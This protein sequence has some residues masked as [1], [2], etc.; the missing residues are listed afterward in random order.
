[1]EEYAKANA[2]PI[3]QPE[4]M[5]FIEVLIKS[6][7]A[8]K[9][10][11][12]GSAIGYSAISMAMCGASVT[13][14]ERDE[15]MLSVVRSNIKK[16]AFDKRIK[17]LAGDALSVVENLSGTFDFIF[18]DAAKGQYPE[19]L[20][21]LLRLLK[22]GGILVSDNILYRGMVATDELAIRRKTTIIKRLRAY[23]DTLCHSDELTTA[24]VP[25]GDGA[26]VSVK[27]SS[28]RQ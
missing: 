21:H 10:L 11:E 1:M 12:I 17:V 27:K 2:I 6:T 4:T 5:R 26:A 3:A 15:N 14:I 9:V 23:L 24:I 20:P 8:K 25:I 7:N 28:N 19:F 18:L 22:D 16:Y 13:T